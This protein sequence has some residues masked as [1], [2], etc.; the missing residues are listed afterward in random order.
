[1]C[2]VIFF[3]VDLLPSFREEKKETNCCFQRDIKSY[4]RESQTITAVSTHK[5]K[6]VIREGNQQIGG[7]K[8]EFVHLGLDSP[9]FYPPTHIPDW[10]A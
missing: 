4:V 9:I 5:R 10:E 2:E 7:W 3:N 8:N 1:M 6:A